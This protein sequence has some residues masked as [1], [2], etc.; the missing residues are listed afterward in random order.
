MM[1]SAKTKSSPFNMFNQAASFFENF[2][3][4]MMGK[5]HSSTEEERF[6]GR[7]RA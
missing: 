5:Q 7:K 4:D 1:S 6:A 3:D 2:M